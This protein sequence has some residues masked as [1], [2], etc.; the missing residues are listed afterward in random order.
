MQDLCLIYFS[1]SMEGVPFFLHQIGAK[2]FRTN[3]V[4]TSCTLF[5]QDVLSFRERLMLRG[6]LKRFDRSLSRC[7][8]HQQHH[9]LSQFKNY[10][11]LEAH[12]CCVIRHEHFVAFWSVSV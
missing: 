12:C 3:N 11:R 6:L 10:G 7:L 2:V 1:L 5:Q 9:V 4:L 8:P